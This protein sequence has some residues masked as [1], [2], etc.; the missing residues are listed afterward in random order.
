MKLPTADTDVNGSGFC[1]APTRDVHMPIVHESSE[2][3]VKAPEV[4]GVV[5]GSQ[6]YDS[7]A[8]GYNSC[9]SHAP[10]KSREFEAASLSRSSDGVLNSEKDINSCAVVINEHP[11]A[12]TMAKTSQKKATSGV[13]DYGQ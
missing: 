6:C 1:D 8:N 13:V 4:R 7:P 10:S 9:E 5:Y 2:W 11:A 12:Y 3:H